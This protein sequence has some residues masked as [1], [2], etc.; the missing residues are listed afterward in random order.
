MGEE[1]GL[2]ICLQ[3][4]FYLSSPL[5]CKTPPLTSVVLFSN[6]WRDCLIL[7]ILQ[8]FP[9]KNSFLF[10]HL[11]NLVPRGRDPFGQRQGSLP[12]PLVKATRTLGTRLPP[13]ASKRRQILS[14]ES[15]R[16]YAQWFHLSYPVEA[17]EACTIF[18]KSVFV[19]FGPVYRLQDEF[20]IVGTNAG[21]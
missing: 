12:V 11:S 14:A 2:L 10:Y 9:K 3:K 13:V 5:L 8:G 18:F 21:I 17:R 6:P 7:L 20:F 19:S 15:S 16:D 4:I 1:E